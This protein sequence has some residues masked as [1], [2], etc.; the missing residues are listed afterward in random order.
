MDP[1]TALALALL[2]L[3]AAAALGLLTLIAGLA[4]VFAQAPRLMEQPEPGTL[5]KI[6]VTHWLLAGVRLL[7][8]HR[9]VHSKALQG[10]SRGA[11]EPS[12]R[13]AKL[14]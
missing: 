3:A 1:A 13:A 11:W 6:M 2:S 9:K 12:V 7:A 10:P 8:L 4:R 5:S 14:F